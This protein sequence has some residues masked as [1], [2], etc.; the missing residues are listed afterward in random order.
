MDLM[1]LVI[2]YIIKKLSITGKEIVELDIEHSLN[3]RDKMNYRQVD[4]NSR[5]RSLKE[6]QLSTRSREFT[7]G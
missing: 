2:D 1:L 6:R 4:I 7:P 3:K 5:C